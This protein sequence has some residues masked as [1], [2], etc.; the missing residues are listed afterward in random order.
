[1]SSHFRPACLAL[2]LIVTAGPVSAQT[3][4]YEPDVGARVYQSR[5]YQERY[6]PRVYNSYNS[7]AYEPVVT[8]PPVSLT[9][10][11]RTV[12][13][14][15]IIPQGRGRGPIVR[16]RIVTER[17]APAPILGER[18]ATPAADYAYIA[19]RPNSGERVIA[20]PVEASY[21]YVV[22]SRD[23]SG[24]RYTYEYDGGRDAAYCQ[25]RFRSYDSAFGTYMGYDGMRHSC[26]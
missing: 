23:A 25:Q 15:T 6:V 1:M 12:I 3:W 16:E 26:P 9:R 2:A 22:G 14:R 4:I 8:G 20:Q 11:Q 17:Y 5:V 19:R 24:P 13:N 18:I 21:A 7:Y 10:T